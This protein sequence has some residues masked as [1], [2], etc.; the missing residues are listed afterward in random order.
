MA[1]RILVTGAAGFAAR[2]LVSSFRDGAPAR[3]GHPREVERGGAAPH[4]PAQ[5]QAAYAP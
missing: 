5:G 2:H 1:E 4:R 3:P